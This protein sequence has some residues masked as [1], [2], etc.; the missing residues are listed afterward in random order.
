MGKI[1]L[2]FDAARKSVLGACAFS[3][4]P[5]AGEF[6]ASPH[7]ILQQIWQTNANISYT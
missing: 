2:R 7:V 6:I 4:N 5:G 1:D 3:I